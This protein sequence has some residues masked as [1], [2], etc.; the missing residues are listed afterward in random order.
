MLL[1][2]HFKT[3]NE[4]WKKQENRTL[5]RF[6]RRHDDLYFIEAKATKARTLELQASQQ[7]NST[8][9]RFLAEERYGGSVNGGHLQTPSR[10][11]LNIPFDAFCRSI[12]NNAIV[13]GRPL[14]SAAVNDCIVKPLTLCSVNVRSAKS[15]SADLLYYIFSSGAD[16]FALTE[17]WL[18]ANDTVA[19]LEFIPPGTHK[20]MHHNRSVLKRD[21]TGLLFRENVE[22]KKIDAGEKTSF[23]LSEWSLSSNSFRATLSIIYRPPC[24]AQLPVTLNT[25]MEEFATYLESYISVPEPLIVTGDLNIM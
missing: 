11:E 5:I 6:S 2:L 25:F 9:V 23:E 10:D 3:C 15:K 16:L 18:N 24:S 12:E 13:T 4:S 22:V 7:A 20:S 14:S 17:T 21:G 19:K 8:Q 1:F